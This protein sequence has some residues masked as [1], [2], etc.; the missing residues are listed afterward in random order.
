MEGGKIH[1]RHTLKGV[2]GVVLD[3][4]VGGGQPSTGA[5][6]I[7]SVLPELLPSGVGVGQGG[8]GGESCYGLHGVQGDVG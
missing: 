3:G 2:A 6:Q 5:L 7:L 4:A 8:Q 1:G